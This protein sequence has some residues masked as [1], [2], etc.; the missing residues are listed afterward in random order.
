MDD[1]SH[2]A[3]LDHSS[4]IAL[5]Q[6]VKTDIHYAATLTAWYAEVDGEMGERP[7]RKP[8]K[9]QKAGA[10]LLVS[11]R[12]AAR[13]IAESHWQRLCECW[14]STRHADITQRLAEAEA[15]REKLAAKELTSLP[16][17]A[18]PV[19]KAR[20]AAKTSEQKKIDEAEKHLPQDNASRDYRAADRSFKGEAPMRTCKVR[21][22]TYFAR[23]YF[24]L[25]YSG[26]G[27]C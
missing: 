15:Q 4:V 17:A 1:E 12:L 14:E 20:A 24:L 21:N 13:A 27:V 2:D 6:L 11:G 3:P 10:K 7:P 16:P 5:A 26:D 18:N 22:F 19:S 9:V 25:V 23:F 8:P